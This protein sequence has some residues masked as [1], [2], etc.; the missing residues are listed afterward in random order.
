MAGQSVWAAGQDR[1]RDASGR[2]ETPV[3]HGIDA[4]VDTDQV[5]DTAHVFDFAGAEAQRQQLGER[6]VSVLSGC[7]P[8]E[9]AFT[10]I[11]SPGG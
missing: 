6:Y 8:S 10:V 3:P 7:Q 5:S 1:C 4:S 9:E 11:H 2:V